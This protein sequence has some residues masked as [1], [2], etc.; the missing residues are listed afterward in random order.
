MFSI[1]Y[2]FG[3]ELILLIL[4]ENSVFLNHWFGITNVRHLNIDHVK[5]NYFV[6]AKLNNNHIW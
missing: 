4:Y 2:V 6:E 3:Q 5:K 1:L